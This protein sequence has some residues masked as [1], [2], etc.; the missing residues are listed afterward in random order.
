MEPGL[1]PAAAPETVRR[2]REALEEAGY[3]QAAVAELAGV[4]ALWSLPGTEDPLVRHRLAGGSRLATLVR[5]FLVGDP[6]SAESA[7]AALQPVELDVWM[8]AGLLRQEGDEVRAQIELQ[9]YDGLLVA[10]DRRGRHAG[11]KS[12]DHVLGINPSSR[13]LANSTMRRPVRSVLDLGAG[14]GIQSLLA[15]R[16]SEQ[17]VAVDRNPRA[18]AFTAFNA[19]LNGFNNIESLEGDLFEPVAG[20]QFD[21]VV[22]NPPYVISPESRFIYRDSGMPGDDFCRRIVQEVPRVLAEGGVCQ[23][24]CNWAQ[25]A[26]QEWRERLAGWFAGS[27]CDAWVMRASTET[28]PAYAAS[29]VR[30]T[31]GEIGE[32]G[33]ARIAEWLAYYERAGIE[34]ISAGLITMQRASNRPNWLSMEEA[35]AQFLE[36]WGDDIA[37]GLALRTFLA[38][39]PEPRA[40]L[41]AR[42]VPSP[43]L[44]LEQRSEAG[45][46]GWTL[47]RSRLRLS[48]GLAYSFRVEP[49]VIELVGRCS[50]DR[51]LGEVIHEVAAWLDRDPESITPSCVAA[52]CRLIERGLLVPVQC[53]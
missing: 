34:A 51:C 38:E 22:G 33:A 23:L 27:G 44:R 18:V 53:S 37:R 11:D 20:R 16:H 46:E 13:T 6:V 19:G 36:R 31:G 15:A 32:T 14:Q 30:T 25:L 21:L 48:R 49:Y 52:A 47:S 35:P 26:G 7:R 50:R 1:P 17:V 2:L 39:R 9:P 8:A 12:P 43:D 3:T 29:W 40:L 45:A 5:L 24:L 41:D 42:L 28:P 10:A 4:E